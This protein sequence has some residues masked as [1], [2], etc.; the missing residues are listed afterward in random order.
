MI[1]L[2]DFFYSSVQ[3]EQE[4]DHPQK[5]QRDDRYDHID[6]TRATQRIRHFHAILSVGA[7]YQEEQADYCRKDC[8]HI[9]Q[10]Y[11]YFQFF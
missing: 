11:V 8:F 1:C 7:R 3:R 10:R 2:L 4:K 6:L 5:Y 9:K